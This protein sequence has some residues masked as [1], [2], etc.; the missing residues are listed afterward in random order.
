MSHNH[1][2]TIIRPDERLA[3]RINDAALMAGLGRSTIYSLINDGKLRSTKVG[4]RRLVL[5]ASLQELLQ[6]GGK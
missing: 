5:R 1:N 3:L 6:A 2:H 4:G